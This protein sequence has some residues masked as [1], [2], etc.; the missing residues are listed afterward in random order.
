MLVEPLSFS[1]HKAPRTRRVS[2]RR[3]KRRGASDCTQTPKHDLAQRPGT[4]QRAPGNGLSPV[5]G[6]LAKT[7][8]DSRKVRAAEPGVEAANTYLKK[9]VV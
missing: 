9:L 3:T 5:P 6:R 7:Y 1:T 8:E 2:I 4:G